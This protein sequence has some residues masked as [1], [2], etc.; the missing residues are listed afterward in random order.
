M[1][2]RQSSTLLIVCSDQDRAVHRLHEPVERLK[3]RIEPSV[4]LEVV[5]LQIGD[6][7][8][9]RGQFQER[10]IA[11][12]CLHHQQVALVPCRSRTDLVHVAANDERRAE[13]GLSQHEGQ[14]GRGGGLAVCAGHGN[15][16]AQSADGT[17]NLGPPV[18]GDATFEGRPALRICVGHRRGARHHSG[19][20]D[21]VR[22]MTHAD[23]HAQCSEAI[24]SGGGL[25][26]RTADGVSHGHQNL[27]NGA[28]A[29]TAHANDVNVGGDR[30]AQRRIRHPGH[31]HTVRPHA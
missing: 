5:G 23:G 19:F 18:E 30:Q 11:L 14:H 27:G 20:A 17:E 16:L 4:V 10:P 21:L 13:T 15:R 1:T 29:G 25:K 8:E 9:P 24:Q 6:Q 31:H 22:R 26:V 12:V 2:L 28:H 7:P 3:E